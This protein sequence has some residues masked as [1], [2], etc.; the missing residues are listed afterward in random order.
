MKVTKLSS[1]LIFSI[2]CLLLIASCTDE[3]GSSETERISEQLQ[4]YK[5]NCMIVD[6]EYFLEDNMT[7]YFINETHGVECYKWR[8]TD[9]HD[10]YTTEYTPFT[11]TI[12]GDEIYVTTSTGSRISFVYAGD[13][14]IR[15]DYEAYNKVSLNSDDYKL[16]KLYDPV[17]IEK[18]EQLEKQMRSYVSFTKEY[19]T[20]TCTYHFSSSLCKKFSPA[21]FKYCIEFGDGDNLDWYVYHNDSSESTFSMQLY[22][23]IGDN[24]GEIDFYMMSFKNLEKKMANGEKLSK[25]EQAFY[26]DLKNVIQGMMA[27]GFK[28]RAY[29]EMNGVKYYLE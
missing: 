6:Y 29:I 5:W 4:S 19:D 28:S 20:F 10:S 18:K 23:A 12:K 16:M 7:L 21:D 15:S 3:G 17:E 14:L 11:Y 8:Y 26:N 25:S 9:T 2:A 1:F 24:W 22:M 27:A 13:C